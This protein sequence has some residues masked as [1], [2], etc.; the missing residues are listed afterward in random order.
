M[1]KYIDDA[2]S[3]PTVYFFSFSNF[4]KLMYKHVRVKIKWK[5]TI[6][7][8]L[9]WPFVLSDMPPFNGARLDTRNDRRHLSYPK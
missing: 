7:L 3:I 1:G 8:F 6:T 4:I 9:S 5:I 2:G